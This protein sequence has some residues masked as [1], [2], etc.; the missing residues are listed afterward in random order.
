MDK[1]LV[2]SGTA[3]STYG[4]LLGVNNGYIDKSEFE[5]NM[6]KVWKYLIQVAL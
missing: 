3:F 6:E 4:I 5:R 1:K 2:L